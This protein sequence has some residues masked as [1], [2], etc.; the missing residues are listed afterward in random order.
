MVSTTVKVAGKR[1]ID[2]PTTPAETKEITATVIVDG[3]GVKGFASNT[4]SPYIFKGTDTGEGVTVADVMKDFFEKSGYKST[5]Y[6][7]GY[8]AYIDSITDPN[9]VTLVEKAEGKPYSGWMYSRN[10][11]YADAINAEFVE[12]GDTIRFYY[13]ENYY[14]EHGEG[15]EEYQ[16]YKALADDVANKIN[17][18]PDELTT[19]NA[20]EYEK[21]VTVA[22]NALDSLDEGVRDYILAEDVKQK[23]YDAE[24]ALAA[25]KAENSD[26]QVVRAMIA[27]LPKASKLKP[28]DRSEVEK[29]YSA[30]LALK[31]AEKA[32]LT[33]EERQKLLDCME[34]VRAY[35]G[36]EGALEQLHSLLESIQDETDVRESEKA[37][38]EE[39]AEIY[40]GLSK[41]YRKLVSR[42]DSAKLKAAQKSLT[43]NE[44]AADKVSAQIAKLTGE[45]ADLTLKNRKTVTAAEKAYDRLTAGQKTFV[46]EADTQKLSAFIA[47]RDYLDK[48]EEAMEANEK[49]AA[50][51]EKLIRKLP[52]ASRIKY[53]D[54]AKVAA[55]EQA[56]KDYRENLADGL[57]DLVTNADVLTAAKT[58]VEAAKA[59][60]QDDIDAA[61]AVIAQIHALPAAGELHYGYNDTED[62]QRVDAAAEAYD[63]LGKE[64]LNYIRAYDKTA[65][66]PVVKKLKA[67][68]KAI[69]KLISQDA[70]DQKAAQ[71]V[72]Q[73][74][75][76]LPEA[77]KVV[78]KNQKA[79]RAAR[80]AYDSLSGNA[81]SYADE[82]TYT[83]DGI[84]V[85]YMK[86]LEACEAA[87]ET[88]AQ[89]EEAADEV[90]TL[91]RKLPA[92]K[93]VKDTD[94]DEIQ[95]VWNR[96][97]NLTK[98]RQGLIAVK[99]VQ[100]LMDCCEAADISTEGNETDLE[101]LALEQAEIAREA[102]VIEQF[103]L[104]DDEDEE[105]S[106]GEDLEEAPD[107]DPEDAQ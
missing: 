27:E 26:V 12:N 32:Q 66:E 68:Q 30:Y 7:S 97:Q 37:F 62:S 42:E 15:S 34:V 1:D 22:R 16:Q 54:E 40:N 19:A 28:D 67:C 70:K 98:K 77:E 104:A 102:A 73:K 3:R 69:K 60:V 51:V 8:G 13:T 76:K 85:S 41:T 31:D 20:T 71:K 103:V 82:L 5:S 11:D 10:D 107:A 48:H 83:A 18:I 75:A 45:P 36:E 94:T 87:L 96:Y 29:V 78:V 64:G 100:K 80:S 95:N 9:G 101:A 21:A 74:I 93:R 57:D 52:S 81:K 24:A 90:E 4:E 99:Y 53:T 44:K 14:L 6:I 55:A 2:E 61:E 79:I 84:S 35:A 105:P 39:A 33:E 59:A 23:L 91:I 89:D 49:A 25:F 106:L 72:A 50:A 38:V 86:K 43:K 65:D 92:A 17:A 46:S 88:A 47:R 63:A 56:Y 58:A